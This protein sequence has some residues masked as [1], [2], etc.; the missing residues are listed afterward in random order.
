MGE[1]RVMETNHHRELFEAMADPVFYPH[2]AELIEQRETHISK[3][4][5]VGEYAYKVKKPFDLGFLDFTTLEKRRHFCQ[6]EI[7]L[8]RRLAHDI[9]M[10]VVPITFEEGRYHLNGRGTPVEYA[11]KMR[12]LSDEDS[13]KS[14]LRKRRIRNSHLKSLALLLADF[15][16]RASE[17]EEIDSTEVWENVRKNCDENFIQTE[18]FTY[19]P[20]ESHISQTEPVTGKIVD[21][22]LLKIVRCTMAG[23]LFRKQ[24]LFDNRAKGGKIKDCHGDLKTEH[25]YF[26]ENNGIQII[27]CIEFNERFR[28]QDIAS[29][30]AFLAMDM[31]FEGCHDLASILLSYY[32]QHADD[33]GI[34]ILL[35]FYKCY[36]AMVRCKVNCFRLNGNDIDRLEREVIMSAAKSYLDLAYGYALK[37]ARPKLFVVC[38]MQASGK[39]TIARELGKLMGIELLSSDLIRKALCKINT[40]DSLVNQFEE[41]IYSKSI[42]NLTYG[43]MLL[44]AQET[45]EAGSSVIL[46]AT[47]TKKHLRDQA[48]L[49]AGDMDATI[50]FIECHA[51]KRLLKKRLILREST[52][53]VSDA[54]I[55]HFEQFISQLEPLDEI[56]EMVHIRVD[57]G[58]SVKECMQHILSEAYLKA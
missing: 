45:L 51:D 43:R 32:V 7:I 48:V 39:S 40:H 47:F 24:I 4:F 44:K 56:D 22:R 13:M 41:G 37:F 14:L 35:D 28:F 52:P 11:L 6:Q 17:C 54:R 49:L 36:R 46:D 23:F 10:D 33:P 31:D 2:A 19:E 29:D 15:Y 58:K 16:N 30:L 53:S 27:D 34:F 1:V 57:T 55:T 42:T 3:V 21:G 50:L 20:L 26:T 25:I 38:G 9:Y 12:R 8:N 18:Q 5:L